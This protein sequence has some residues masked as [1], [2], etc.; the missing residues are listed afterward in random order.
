MSLIL[1]GDNKKNNLVTIQVTGSD[2]TQIFLSVNVI[3]LAINFDVVTN[4]LFPSSM[5]IK[6]SF[7][8]Y[9]NEVLS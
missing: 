9:L 5:I 6:D 3:I 2:K 4:V 1:Y 8:V 7:I